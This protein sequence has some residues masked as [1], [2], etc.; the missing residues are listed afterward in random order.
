[1]CNFLHLLIIY[2]QIILITFKILPKSVAQK[3]E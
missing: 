3:N 2:N 1:M